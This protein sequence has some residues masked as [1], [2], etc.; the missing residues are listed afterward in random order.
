MSNNTNATGL[1][2]PTKQGHIG[3]PAQAAYND[4]QQQNI[5]QTA[6]INSVGGG[7]KK[8]RG[9]AI[10]VPVLQTSYKTTGSPEQSPTG[11][12]ASNGRVASLGGENAKYDNQLQQ[13]GKRCKRGGNPDWLWG[14]Y[15][16]GKKR[17]TRTNKRKTRRYRKKTRRN[18]K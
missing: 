3:S 17:K 9:G 16:G 15:S 8:K 2:P 6:L 4:R 1:P 7:S 14:C 5:S 18:K 11:I 10:T 12:A 13:G